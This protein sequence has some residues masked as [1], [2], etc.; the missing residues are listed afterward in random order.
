MN[1]FIFFHIYICIFINLHRTSI[2][3]KKRPLSERYKDE[4]V[5]DFMT[6]L[7]CYINSICYKRSPY[8]CCILGRIQIFSYIRH[9]EELFD[10]ISCCSGYYTFYTYV[11]RFF[12]QKWIF[13]RIKRALYFNLIQLLLSF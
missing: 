11:Y 12:N 10:W 1:C 7:N 4:R 8:Y 13:K 6:T 5:S 2:V 9:P 3:I